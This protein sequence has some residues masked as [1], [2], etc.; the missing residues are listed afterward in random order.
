MRNLGFHRALAVL[1]LVGSA[2]SL[3]ADGR[4]APVI[5]KQYIAEFSKV[6]VYLPILPPRP[7]V[8]PGL[9]I[10]ANSLSF[11]CKQGS[12]VS[13]RDLESAGIKLIRSYSSEIFT[14]AAIEVAQDKD[15][16]H[17]ADAPHVV[18]LWPNR[19]VP[20]QAPLDFQSFSGHVAVSNYSTLQVT[21][22]EQ[23]HEAGILGH[24]VKVG[25]LDS[26]IWYDHPDLGG[27]FGPG[28]KVAGG[29]DF[30]G[31]GAWPDGPKEPNPDPKDPLNSYLDVGHGT[32]VAGI[33]VST[34]RF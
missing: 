31:N 1:F 10:C 6:R 32:H 4:H 17:Y 2:F 23:L 8:Q 20:R 33:I 5:P 27:G 29:W 28:F 19:A 18:N 15:A 22:V 34:A 30:V 12:A 16:H 26:G 7:Q 24:G 14:G 11:K 21:G 25:V 3:K 13:R 9:V